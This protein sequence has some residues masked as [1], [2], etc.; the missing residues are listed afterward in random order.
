MTVIELARLV[1]MAPDV[2]RYYA[3]IGLLKPTRNPATTISNLAQP[4]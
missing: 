2:I 4:T 3:R 1:G